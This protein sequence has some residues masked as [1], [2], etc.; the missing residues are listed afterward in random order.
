MERLYWLARS[1]KGEPISRQDVV[2]AFTT[3]RASTQRGD[4]HLQIRD[5][6]GAENVCFPIW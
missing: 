4:V 6:I 5:Y 2:H 3:Y 1:R